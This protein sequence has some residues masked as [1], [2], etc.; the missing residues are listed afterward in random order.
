HGTGYASPALPPGSGSNWQP[1]FDTGHCERSG[2][3]LHLRPD[4]KQLRTD[5]NAGARAG[6]ARLPT[7]ARLWSG[8]DQPHRPMKNVLELAIVLIGC[9]IVNALP[10]AAQEYPP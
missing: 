6:S 4:D 1:L 10:A 5:A 8:R 3:R 2:H 9:S 7:G